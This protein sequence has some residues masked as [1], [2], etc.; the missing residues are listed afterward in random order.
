MPEQHVIDDAQIRNEV[1]LLIDHPDAEVLRRARPIDRDD[2]PIDLDRSG[3]RNVRARERLHER[4]FARPVLAHERVHFARPHV[5]R[6]AVERFD[7]GKRFHDP[8]H[9]QKR[10]RT[11]RPRF[12]QRGYF[13]SAFV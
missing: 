3:V 12:R 13:A 11:G 5:E 7:P 6:H 4:R 9:A 2:L 1:E 10:R 8:V